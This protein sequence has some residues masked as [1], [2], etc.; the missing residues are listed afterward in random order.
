MAHQTPPK[1][2]AMEGS[3]NFQ[4]G[5]VVSGT[6]RVFYSDIKANEHVLYFAFEDWWVGDL[7]PTR[8]FE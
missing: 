3:R 7:N 6:L 5:F 4:Q 1:I 8:K 2:T